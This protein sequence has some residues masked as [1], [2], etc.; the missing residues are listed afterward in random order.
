[1]RKIFVLLLLLLPIAAFCG[2]NKK[3]VDKKKEDKNKLIQVSRWC[4]VIRM[5]PDSSSVP[6]IDTMYISFQP[7]DS[8]SYHRRNGFVYEGTF[9]VSEDSILDFGTARYKVLERIGHDMV[10]MNNTGIFH[11]KQDTSALEK[12]IVIAKADTAVP[13]TNIDQM[14]GHWTVYKRTSDGPTEIDMVKNI[15]SVFIT[16]ASTEGKLGYVYGGTDA[17]NDPSWYIKNFTSDQSL[18]CNGKNP[19]TL[20]VNRCQDGELILEEEGIKYYFKQFK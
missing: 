19:R 11:F 18:D 3:K 8:F 1:M 10:L 17:D 14:I 2:D 12:A 5:H 7:K 6:F 20:K 16:G 4:E 9:K 15:R 13:V